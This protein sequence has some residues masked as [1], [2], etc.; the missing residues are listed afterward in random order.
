MNLFTHRGI[1]WTNLPSM[2]R[3]YLF[4][5]VA[6]RRIPA[7]DLYELNLWRESAPEARTSCSRLLAN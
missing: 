5:R 3:Q 4:D 1:R 6:D 7:D 2:L